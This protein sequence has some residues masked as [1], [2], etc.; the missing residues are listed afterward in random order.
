VPGINLN[1]INSAIAARARQGIGGGLTNY[2]AASATIE[3]VPPAD[4]IRRWHARPGIMI[5]V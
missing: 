2:A 5:L 4:E 3:R 1:N